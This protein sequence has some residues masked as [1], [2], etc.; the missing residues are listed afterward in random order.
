ML[1][2]IS[3][4]LTK[5]KVLK[6]RIDEKINIKQTITATLGTILINLVIFLIPMLLLYN[7]M[8]FDQ[9][10]WLLKIIVFVL[11]FLFSFSYNIFFV[12]IIK[13]YNENL[14][15]NDFKYLII[16]ESTIIFLVLSMF[17]AVIMVLV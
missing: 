11:I 14:E 15:K 17:A 16:F 8:I 3:L 2:K 1:K 7:L 12:K 4:T 9:I 6:Q 5:Y 10:I 13:N